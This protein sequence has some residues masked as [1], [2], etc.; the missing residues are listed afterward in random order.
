MEVDPSSELH[1]R[2]QGTEYFFCSDKCLA[3]FLGDPDRFLEHPKT[4]PSISPGSGKPSGGHQRQ[5]TVA[6]IEDLGMAAMAAA[7]LFMT[8]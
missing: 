7:M 6:L 8:R 5:E 2:H 1:A 4:E 3:R